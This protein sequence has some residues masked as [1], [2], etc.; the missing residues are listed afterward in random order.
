MTALYEQ[1]GI[2]AGATDEEIRGAYKRK[3]QRTHPDKNNGDR[4]QYDIVRYA[5][6]VL[7]DPE[8]RARYD[9]NGDTSEP[10][11]TQ[12]SVIEERLVILFSQ[13]LSGDLDALNRTDIV[14][15]C[16]RAID[17]ALRELQTALGQ[18]DTTIRQHERLRDRLTVEGEYNAFSSLIDQRLEAAQR[19]RERIVDDIAV[20]EGMRELLESYTDRGAPASV[21]TNGGLFGGI[22]FTSTR[23]GW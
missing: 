12:A 4:E 13:I 18:I 10:G 17:K 8:R 11:P 23:S 16:N 14:A 21:Q 2:S 19:N 22:G 9:R 3:A 20:H 1:L 6:N 7:S 5:Y 15:Q